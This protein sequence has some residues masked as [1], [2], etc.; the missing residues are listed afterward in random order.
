ML[1][2]E[3]RSGE[4][5]T[6]SR[7]LA[8][9]RSFGQHK[10]AAHEAAPGEAS[11]TGEHQLWESLSGL[12]TAGGTLGLAVSPDADQPGELIVSAWVRTDAGER[13]T[14][15]RSSLGAA[16]LAV[17]GKEPRKVCTTCREEKPLES[18]SRKKKTRASACK[19]CERERVR[20]AKKRKKPSA[21]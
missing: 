19:V 2:E 5:V 1:I 11:R 14:E 15:T 18:F 7:A 17:A 21:A 9:V 4:R 3:A 6:Y 8:L 16:V 13:R 20:K 10:P 12:I